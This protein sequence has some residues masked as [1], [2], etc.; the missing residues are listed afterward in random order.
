MFLWTSFLS[1]A[2]D[3][4]VAVRYVSKGTLFKTHFYIA[5]C[6]SVFLRLF[7]FWTCGIER[8]ILQKGQTA[9]RIN[10]SCRAGWNVHTQQ[11]YY[12]WRCGTPLHSYFTGTYA[13]V[14]ML[15][16]WGNSAVTIEYP[17]SY[18]ELL[19]WSACVGTP[20]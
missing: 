16:L 8:A 4:N 18:S 19:C 15:L 6:L 9:F 11:N 17:H 20:R 7:L 14:T 5:P 13:E 10:P 1:F 12:G 3:N 2:N